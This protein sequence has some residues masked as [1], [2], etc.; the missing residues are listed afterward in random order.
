MKKEIMVEKEVCDFCK[1]KESWDGAPKCLL[2]GGVFCDDCLRDRSIMVYFKAYDESS[3]SA[4]MFCLE[5]Y[6]K[7]DPELLIIF[8]EFDKYHKDD[9]ERQK[10]F[11]KKGLELNKKMQDHIAKLKSQGIKLGNQ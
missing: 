5:C 10:Q 7:L 2:C 1:E 9:Q 6:K 11:R 8:D 4:E 3:E